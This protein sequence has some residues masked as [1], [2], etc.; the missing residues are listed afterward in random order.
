MCIGVVWN[1]EA[2]MMFW[3]SCQK[4][5]PSLGVAHMPHPGD[6]QRHM[7]N[8]KQ[9]VF[10]L[11][12]HIFSTEKE[13]DLQ[14]T[15]RESLISLKWSGGNLHVFWGSNSHQISLFGLIYLRDPPP[16]PPPRGAPHPPYLPA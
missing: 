16:Y 14:L 5:A 8:V 15:M 6:I 2:D 4:T 3:L 1:S 7:P 10:L 9:G 13:I 12:L 11:A